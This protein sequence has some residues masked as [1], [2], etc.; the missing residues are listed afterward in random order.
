VNCALVQPSLEAP[1]VD[2]L[3]AFIREALK[4]ESETDI[5]RTHKAL[6]AGLVDLSR[7]YFRSRRIECVVSSDTE[8]SCPEALTESSG[9]RTRTGGSSTT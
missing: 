2:F 5:A 8:D 3:L 6:G 1:A 9:T 7:R 4:L